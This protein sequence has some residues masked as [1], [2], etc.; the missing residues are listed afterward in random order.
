MADQLPTTISEL[1]QKYTQGDLTVAEVI[2]YYKKNL[3][4]E[5]N[6]IGAFLEIFSH[7]QEYIDRVQAMIDAGDIKP[8]TGVPVS[9]KDNMLYKG[10]HASAGSQILKGYTATYDA[11]VVQNL[12]E[13][14]ALIIGRTNMD[15]FA[16]GSSTET[17]SYLQTKNP[18]NT[19]YVPGGSSGGAAAS[20]AMN[21]GVM[22]ALGSDT[23]GSIRQPAS[24]CGLVGLK[25]TYGT[26]S[27]SG[28]MAMASSL[29]II[30]PFTKTVEDAEKT[31]YALAQYD[32]EDSTSVPQDIRD[33]RTITDTPKK[34]GIP[35]SF[36]NMDGI[37]Q[38]VRDNF[39]ASITL[40]EQAG[41]E[42]VDIDMKLLEHALSVYYILMPAEVSSNLARFDGVRYGL[43][44][45]GENIIDTYNKT[46]SEGFGDEVKRR[47]L[48]GTY[49]LS[50]GYYDAYY[51][52]ALRV[53]TALER[54]FAD[55]FKEVDAIATP[56]TP[57]GAFTFGEKIDNPLEMYMSDIF[58]VPANIAG[59]PA[60]SIPSGV[61]GDGMPLGLHITAPYL[62][63]STLFTIGK[64]FEK[65]RDIQKSEK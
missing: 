45:E 48:L 31:Y 56:T 8:L 4:S 20:V 25:P 37:S 6:T 15:E 11:H 21:H 33:K 60:L 52:K 30:G 58:T 57:S 53:R 14:G 49:V 10:H 13:Q 51:N 59:I 32:P 2:S 18:V 17:S 61:N 46:R 22:V 5:N 47:I 29:D 27:R 9:I 64:D 55:I 16:M 26:L 44:T 62:G 42:I 7:D 23:G 1:H 38:D 50:H 28:L 54:E 43:R 39:N 24:F 40:L 12:K 34:I 63:E 36:I 35:R 19:D 65:V 3:E 41:Y